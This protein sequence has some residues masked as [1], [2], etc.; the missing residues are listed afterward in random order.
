MRLLSLAPTPTFALL[1]LLSASQESSLHN[2][3]C[4]AGHSSPLTGMVSM[5]SLMSVFHSAPWIR[6]LVRA[7]ARKRF[8]A[9]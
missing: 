7:S 6:M 4:S 5:Y 3:V 1:A 9:C 2:L 8:G